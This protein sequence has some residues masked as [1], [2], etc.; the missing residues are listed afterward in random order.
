MDKTLSKGETLTAVVEQAISREVAHRKTQAEF[1]RRGLAAI[2]LTEKAGDGIPSAA[3]IATLDARLAEAR[4]VM[5]AC[6]AA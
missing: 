2:A 1:V 5:P 4:K 3:I 6:A